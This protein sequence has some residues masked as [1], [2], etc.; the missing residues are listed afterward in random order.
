MAKLKTTVQRM[1]DDWI[2]PE[3]EALAAKTYDL[4]MQP[5]ILAAVLAWPSMAGWTAD[6]LRPA[7][8]QSV[9]IP[10]WEERL[11]A[12]KWPKTLLTEAARRVRADEE[13]AEAAPAETPKKSERD[14]AAYVAGLSELDQ[15]AWLVKTLLETDEA[16]LADPFRKA[17]G[18]TVTHAEIRAV[19]PPEVAARLAAV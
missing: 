7:L 15:R 18:R 19:I 13:R 17:L 16:A 14:L 1:S 5:Q 6:S 3:A 12:R 8:L 11:R 9:L 4:A 2:R 10:K